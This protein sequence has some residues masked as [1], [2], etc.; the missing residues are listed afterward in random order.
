M[1]NRKKITSSLFIILLLAMVFGFN[2]TSVSALGHTFTN[3][4]GIEISESEY[5]NLLGLGFS[6][7]EI[8][9]MSEDD[10]LEN[11]DIEATIVGATTKYY[12]T[13]VP[14]FGARYTTEVTFAEYLNSQSINGNQ[15]LDYSYTYYY[16]IVSTISARNNGKYRY[17]ISVNWLNMPP[18]NYFDVIGI[19]FCDDVYIDSTVYFV[20][21]YD[22]PDST[23]IQ[24]TYF[25]DKKSTAVGGSAVYELPTNNVSLSATLYYDVSKDTN[26]TITEL[27]MCGDYSHAIYSVYP[28]QAANHSISYYGIT[29]DSSV[30]LNFEQ[31]GCTYG[32][33][34]NI[35]W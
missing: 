11:K 33:A 26:D 15:P 7:D 19:G 35:S 28:Q 24:S 30:V 20:Y 6:A 18:D 32:H 13:V 12:K 9:Y 2:V 1:I 14:Y 5:A 21:S 4:Y 3:Y 31:V 23:H 34:Y 16:E 22:Y 10:Y 27:E 17:K 29:F 8:Y 25:Y